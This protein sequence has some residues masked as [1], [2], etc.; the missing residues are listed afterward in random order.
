[1]KFVLGKP[2]K[3]VGPCWYL[4]IDCRD[5]EK[6]VASIIR[7]NAMKFAKD[8]HKGDITAV[9]ALKSMVMAMQF[10]L[11]CHDRDG[12]YVGRRGGMCPNLVEIIKE[13]E[14]DN[15]PETERISITK[16][17]GGKHY[18]ARVDEQDVEWGGLNKWSTN[19]AAREAAVKFMEKKD[20]KR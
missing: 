14:S 13:V 10:D 8:P 17:P 9:L 7:H 1:M 20:S 5:A 6:Y 18:Y 12:W 3:L 11:G 4:V 19:E 2:H 15:W 16:W